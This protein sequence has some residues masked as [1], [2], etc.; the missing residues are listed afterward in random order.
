MS[1]IVSRPARSFQGW[2]TAPGPFK[3][4]A[5]ILATHLLFAIIGIFWT[6]FGYAEM[7]G[8]TAAFRRVV[9]ALDGT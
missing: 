5:I 6:P 2:H 7:G 9:A 1:A 3:A 8:G 4:G